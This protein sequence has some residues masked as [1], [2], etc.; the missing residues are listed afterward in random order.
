MSNVSIHNCQFVGAI[1][2][3]KSIQAVQTVAQALLNLT[4]LFKSQGISVNSLLTINTEKSEP[5]VTNVVPKS[6]TPK[7]LGAKTPV[8]AKHVTN[9]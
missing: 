1:W 5:I 2:E 3:E 8:G 7:V 6:L 4:D 9:K